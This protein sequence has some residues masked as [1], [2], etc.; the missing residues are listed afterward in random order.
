[1]SPSVASVNVENAGASV[2]RFGGLHDGHG[3]RRGED[4]ARNGGI[5]H[6]LADETGMKGLMTAAATADQTDLAA[7]RAV[8]ERD[9]VGEREAVQEALQPALPGRQRVLGQERHVRPVRALH[10][11]VAR[12]AV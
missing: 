4:L 3:G 1:M 10:Q 7:D 5:E 11:E 6:A 8:D 9:I 2:G 12:A